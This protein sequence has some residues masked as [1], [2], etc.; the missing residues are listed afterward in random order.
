LS[1][2]GIV[3]AFSAIEKLAVA[4]SLIGV[5][6]VLL[7]SNYIMLKKNIEMQEGLKSERQ[8][9]ENEKKRN[10]KD[11]VQLCRFLES[12]LPVWQSQI[13]LATET[14]ATS[15]GG[16]V[17]EFSGM[18]S[19]LTQTL[20]YSNQLAHSNK[21]ETSAEVIEKGNASLIR[22]INEL[23]DLLG[24]NKDIA[25]K[26]EGLHGY[27]EKLKSMAEDVAGIAEQTNLLALNASIEAARA[28]EYG[29]G[30]AVVADEVRNLSKRSSCT[31]NEMAKTIDEICLAMEEAIKVTAD[32]SRS[33]EK[34]IASSHESVSS[35]IDKFSII[36]N[37]LSQSSELMQEE[38]GKILI[39]VSGVMTGLQFQDRVEQI[40][41]NTMIQLKDMTSKFSEA[42]Q[43]ED[44]LSIVPH[45][46]EWKRDVMASFNM[47]EQKKA[48]AS[49]SGEAISID[50]GADNELEFF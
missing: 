3:L 35:V 34:V 24:A 20:E 18:R 43:R 49:A 9:F 44:S 23:S 37:N 32:N 7:I 29:R 25:I 41:T 38:S 11:L 42:G 5:I 13:Q 26:I 50:Q 28:G 1:I 2:V 45:L 30:F 46:E 47:V 36:A 16:L 8:D 27:A 14:T 33:S 4:I 31:G 19:A 12:V 6:G 39:A 40:L 21:S 22:V 48:F 17:E 10:Q 15:I